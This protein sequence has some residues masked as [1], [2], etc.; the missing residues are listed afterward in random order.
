MPEI[1]K[2][3][4]VQTRKRE[5]VSALVSEYGEGA[6]ISLKQ[7]LVVRD[8]LSKELYTNTV[9]YFRKDKDYKIGRNQYVATVAEPPT[10]VRDK[11]KER[12][13][14]EAELNKS[15]LLPAEI[16]KS[17]K[18]LAEAIAGPE[19]ITKKTTKPLAEQK[20]VKDMHDDEGPDNSSDDVSDI[21]RIQNN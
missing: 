12:M 21:L 17:A 3:Q 18:K 2:S 4:E 11:T 20:I 15:S 14:K 9:E 1:T 13:D 5:L 19:A 6:V 16:R 8:K 10:F 7:I